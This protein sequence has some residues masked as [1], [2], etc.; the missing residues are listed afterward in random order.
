MAARRSSEPPKARIFDELSGHLLLLDGLD[1]KALSDIVQR[2]FGPL[3]EY[4]AAHRTSLYKTLYTLFE[5]HLAVQQTADELHIHRN[6]LQKRTGARRGS[7]SASTSA[8]STPSSTSASGC[9]GCC[10]S[11]ASSPQLDRRVC[12]RPAF[13]RKE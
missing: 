5:N 9:S 4:D 6:T 12:T 1:Q 2:T 13:S 10:H 7:C 11:W 8:S 3:L